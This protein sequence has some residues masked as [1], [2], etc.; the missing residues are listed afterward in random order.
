MVKKIQIVIGLMVSLLV[1]IGIG[2]SLLSNRLV[3]TISLVLKPYGL[4][5]FLSPFLFGK[6]LINLSLLLDVSTLT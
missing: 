2:N 3:R 1:K 4:N 6:L 5:M